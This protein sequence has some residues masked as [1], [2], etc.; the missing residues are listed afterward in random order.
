MSDDKKTID[1]KKAKLGLFN[2]KS[3]KSQRLSNNNDILRGLGRVPPPP[4]KNKP[5][6]KISSL[7]EILRQREQ[8]VKDMKELQR[9]MESD[10]YTAR[11]LQI[12]HDVYVRGQPQL[13]TTEEERL[14]LAESAIQSG[15]A[16]YRMAKEFI[17]YVAT[18]DFI[19][20]ILEE[21]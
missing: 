12:A 14:A 17:E 21:K 19:K 6:A 20:S 10:E 2:N 18:E 3:N 8:D 7:D 16:F 5:V 1:F 9:R 4:L 15:Q 13:L 11:V